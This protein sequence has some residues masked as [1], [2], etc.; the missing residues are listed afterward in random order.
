MHPRPIDLIPAM[1]RSTFS[2]RG[3]LQHGAAAGLAVLAG[4]TMGRHLPVAAYQSSTPLA[5]TGVHRVTVGAF[6][7]TVIA[8]GTAAFPDPTQILFPTAPGPELEEALREHAAPQPW[9]E[10]VTPFNALLVDTGR[11]RVLIDTG[12]GGTVAPTAGRLLANLRAVGVEPPEVDIVVLSHGH[13][14][15]IGG[16]TDGAG[17]LTF[18]NAR[19]LMTRADWEF[20]TDEA[21]VAEHVAPGDFR[22]LQIAFAQTHLTPLADRIDLV[23]DGDEVVPGLTIVLA[24]GHSPGHAVVAIE[25]DGERLLY[26][27]DIV[28]HPIHVEHPDWLTIFDI[29]PEPTV[30]SRR[31]V[32]ADAAADGSLVVAY[33]IPFPGLGRIQADGDAFRWSPA[34]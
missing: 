16:A 5:G 4:A 3:V 20:W 26:G 2:R 21:T 12:F 31:R 14:D 30:S 13:P 23:E 15:H 28:L 10:W 24:P 22:D 9:L 1:L 18:P 27:A 34:S 29:H 25:S 7:A 32:L 17:T 19:Y 6:A 33:H 8:D 11:E